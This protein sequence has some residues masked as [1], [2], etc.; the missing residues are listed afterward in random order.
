MYLQMCMQRT[1]T[2]G[3]C[4]VWRKERMLISVQEQSEVGVINGQQVI[5]VAPCQQESMEDICCGVS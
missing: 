3:R 4:H 1:G 2:E 5:N